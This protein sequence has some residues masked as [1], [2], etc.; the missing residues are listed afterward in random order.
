MRMRR[1]WAVPAA[2]AAVLLCSAV[3]ADELVFSSGAVLTGKV[4]LGGARVRV[5]TEHGAFVVSRGS[6]ARVT[7]GGVT[8]VLGEVE[9]REAVAAG[10]GRAE[11]PQLSAL[12]E[13]PAPRPVGASRGA[14]RKGPRALAER[15]AASPGAVLSRPISVDFDATPVADAIE[16][17]REA[18][19]LDFA[20]RPADLRA[21]VT[22]V[23]L[24]LKRVRA[25]QV[26]D[27]TLEQVALGWT[28]KGNVVQ[29]RP[30]D[31]IGRFELRGYDV[32]DLL[33][34]GHD[35]DAAAGRTSTLAQ[36]WGGSGGAYGGGFAQSGRGRGGYGGNRGYRCDG[37]FGGG[38]QSSQERALG[39]ATLITELI[40]PDSWDDPAVTV[41]G[42][43]GRGI[44]RRDGG[45]EWRDPEVRRQ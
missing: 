3:A 15:P 21:G 38:Y 11:R 44:G 10:W 5:V 27:L 34:N 24:R 29:V 18:T 39:L 30:D 40:R 28:L 35:A 4:H 8:T 33:V 17:L 31:E 14:V 13:A 25:S 20:Y 2:V 6:V 9:E 1:D 23:S 12:A 16:Y 22:V 26:L 32:R 37:G 45:D 42:A 19:G 43:G 36:A 41:G 7:V